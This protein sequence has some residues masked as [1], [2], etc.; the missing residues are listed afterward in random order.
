MAENTNNSAVLETEELLVF[1]AMFLISLR[2]T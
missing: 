2:F 1:S